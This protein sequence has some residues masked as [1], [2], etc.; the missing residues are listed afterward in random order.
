MKP[1][2]VRRAFGWDGLVAAALLLAT[3]A[4]WWASRPV[5]SFVH[6]QLVRQLQHVQR[7]AERTRLD[8]LA[9]RYGRTVHYD[10]V[11]AHVEALRRAVTELERTL[12]QSVARH[13]ERVVSRGRRIVEA[14]DAMV[15]AVEDYKSNNAVLGNS[16][17]YLF[18]YGDEFHRLQQGS[19]P[20]LV[21]HIETL[22]RELFRRQ[23][24]ADGASI[25][26]LQALHDEIK[27]RVPDPPSR[28][29][30]AVEGFLAHAEIAVSYEDAVEQQLEAMFASTLQRAV[31]GFRTAYADVIR[32]KRAQVAG[33]RLALGAAAAGLAVFVAV[34]LVRIR[35]FY[36]GLENEVA[37]RT[38]ELRG[39]LA[40]LSSARDKAERA[41]SAKSD[42][43][44]TMSHEIRT[45]LN[46]V[47]GTTQLLAM[48][49]LD[50]E[51]REY[52][53]TLCRSGE[54]LM[55]LINDIL[56]FSKIEA[57][58]LNL[59]H[60]AFELEVNLRDV[61]ELMR[62]GADE[63]GISLSLKLSDGLPVA[64]EGDPARLRQIMLNLVSNAIKFTAQGGVEISV[65]VAQADPVEPTIEF[66]VQD[67]GIGISQDAQSRIFDSFSQAES[68]T[69]RRFG[70]TGLG[71]AICKRIAVAMRGDIG[72]VS[73][74]GR[75]STFW[76][77]VPLQIGA[78]VSAGSP[79]AHGSNPQIPNRRSELRLLVAEDNPVNRKLVQRGLERA[80]YHVELVHNGEE[81]VVAMREGSYDLVLMDCQMPVMDGFQAT[82]A[83][84]AQEGDGPR[85]PIIALTA[86]ASDEDRKTC[87]ASG[88]NGHLAKPI[89]F[90]ELYR[91]IDHACGSASD[92]DSRAA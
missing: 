66:R 57:G 27:Q 80:G 25:T 10:D 83:I 8:V 41:A 70:G 24:F 85:I 60:V 29:R 64:V 43:L 35:S 54:G 48:T 22:E 1:A 4:L 18:R 87:L 40:E 23:M 17:R 75:G 73:E 51:Q 89:R 19:D 14:V 67:T 42:F 30:V 81:A 13:D 44:A 76:V 53:D 69:T 59:E 5:D 56:D 86:N 77:R 9:T 78:T 21:Q 39:A 92:G 37:Q 12:D 55:V 11:V 20:V 88:M 79:V 34:L 68:S 31:A 7:S 45:P 82:R 46:G 61:V 49:H 36:R 38:S 50:E 52:V 74:V 6:D 84:R 63:K 71:L 72:V 26:H 28:A 91:A 62:S 3:V 15:A 47:M 32:N 90:E 16:L 65:R 2:R 33:F 58:Q